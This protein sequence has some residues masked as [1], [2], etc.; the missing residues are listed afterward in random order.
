MSPIRQ[1][2]TPVIKCRIFIGILLIQ[3][4]GH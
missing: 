3:R 1:A 4:Y 2:M